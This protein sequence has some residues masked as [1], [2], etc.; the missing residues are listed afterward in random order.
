MENA[1][2]IKIC[3][4][5]NEFEFNFYQ[6][7][8]V[9]LSSKSS[10]EAIDINDVI[11]LRKAIISGDDVNEDSNFIVENTDVNFS[12]DEIG[13]LGD[14]GDIISIRMKILNKKWNF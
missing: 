1:T 4:Q 3:T 14:I 5:E 11:K 7:G 9:Y 6:Q 13:S 10:N 2:K 8:N 12:N